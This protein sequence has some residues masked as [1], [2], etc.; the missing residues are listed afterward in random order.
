MNRIPI[1]AAVMLFAGTAAAH[2]CPIPADAASDAI[3]QATIAGCQHP[4]TSGKAVDYPYR[5]F[6]VRIPL[7]RDVPD[8]GVQR[9]KPIHF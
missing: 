1:V 9:F 3:Q 4:E 6:I 8:N 7:Q 2:Q 5:W